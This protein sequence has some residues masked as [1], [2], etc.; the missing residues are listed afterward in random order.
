MKRHNVRS[1][2]GRF[3]PKTTASKKYKRTKANKTTKAKLIISG[4]L[5]DSSGSM[6][7]KVKSVIEGF[8]EL[9]AQGKDDFKKTGVITKEVVA[10]FGGPANSGWGSQ[11]DTDQYANFYRPHY[12]VCDRLFLA[13]S[14]MVGMNGAVGYSADLGNTALW[15]S[16]AKL[17]Q[18]LEAHEQANPGA[19]VILTIFTDGD[20]NSSSAE[21]KNGVK[22]KAII[23]AKQAQGWVITFMGAGDKDYVTRVATSVGIFASNSMHYANSS[24]GTTVTMDAMKMSRSNYTSNVSK[25]TSSNIGFFVQ[26]PE[27]KKK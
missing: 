18:Q 16:T 22:I 7:G 23:E 19:K 6:S 27:N 10:F 13:A 25:G 17:I 21:W 26:E 3:A 1:S 20:E 4:F 24:A 15:E 11:P 5:L 14:G 8:N 12:G 9:I 2:N